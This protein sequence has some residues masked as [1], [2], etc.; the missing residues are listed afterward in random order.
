MIAP[1][2]GLEKQVAQ[3][4]DDTLWTDNHRPNSRTCSAYYYGV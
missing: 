3:V 4:I 1:G 2:K